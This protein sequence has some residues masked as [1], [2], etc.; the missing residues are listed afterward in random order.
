MLK[1]DGSYE[2]VDKRGKVL[3]SSQ[4]YFCEKAREEAKAPEEKAKDRVFEPMES[5]E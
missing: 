5:I 3:L 4:D 2:K 1:T